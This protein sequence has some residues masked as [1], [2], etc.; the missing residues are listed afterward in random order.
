MKRAKFRT[1]LVVLSILLFT[2]CASIV[3][4]PTAEIRVTSEPDKAIV[5]LNGYD[6]GVTPMV[7]ELNRKEYH[8]ITFI[9]NGYNRTSIQINPKFDFFT[10]VLGNVV[11]WNIIGVVVD[12]H[13]G[14]AYTLSPAD[15]EGNLEGIVRF[16]DLKQKSRSKSDISVVLFTQNQWDTVT[17]N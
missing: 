1:Q 3:K 12:L 14:A 4:G 8:N 16:A 11:S 13:T 7:L 10:T 9:L 6:I 5:I 17:S 15:V 2:S